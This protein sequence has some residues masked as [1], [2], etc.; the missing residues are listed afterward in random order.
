MRGPGWPP[1]GS[2]PADGQVR[3]W[4]E[5]LNEATGFGRVPFGPKAHPG[6]I[7]APLGP[8]GL[9]FG[10]SLEAVGLIR[11]DADGC[12]AGEFSNHRVRSPTG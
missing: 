6:F 3:V 4:D 9:R 12:A 7:G 2:E 11:F 1:V 5:Y 8:E 10:F